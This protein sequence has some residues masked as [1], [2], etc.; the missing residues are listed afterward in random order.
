MVTTSRIRKTRGFFLSDVPTTFYR[1]TWSSFTVEHYLSL[2]LTLTALNSELSHVAPHHKHPIYLLRI[3]SNSND[4]LLYP[5]T[6]ARSLSPITP[7][8]ITL[9][10]AEPCEYVDYE[11]PTQ[12]Y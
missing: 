12:T 9:L 2:L 5:I 4:S 11:R 7:R 8:S 6:P 1:N 3:T 10:T